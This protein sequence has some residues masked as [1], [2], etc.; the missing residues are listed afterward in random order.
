MITALLPSGLLVIAGVLWRIIEPDKQPAVVLRQRLNTVA[1]Y[2]LI[3]ALILNVMLRSR[4]DTQTWLLPLAAW[5]T[6]GCCLLV[7]V[8]AYR[9][10]FGKAENRSKGAM[11]LAGSFGNGVGV[12]APVVIAIYGIEA[13]RVPILYTL[14]GSLPITWTLGVAIALGHGGEQTAPMWRELLRSPPLWAALFGLGIALY[15]L[16]IPAWV[17]ETLE[18]LSRAAVPLMLFAVGLSLN[19]KGIRRI[20]VAAPAIITKSL[21][22]PL[23]ACGIGVLLGLQGITLGALVM[24]AATASF[25]VGVVL[26]DRYD[27]DVDLYGITV[28]VTAILYFTLLPLWTLLPDFI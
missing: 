17:T 19:L 16:P 5:L 11:I 6:I 13:A 8:C 18:M 9:T 4:V 20:S 15:G 3:P 10:L 27:L 23:I 22:S 1:I 14:L 24:T 28:A 7:N 25:N 21:I 26:S 12:A 2:L